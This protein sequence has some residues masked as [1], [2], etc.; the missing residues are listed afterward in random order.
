MLLY[1]QTPVGEKIK[2][3]K[4]YFDNKLLESFFR[5]YKIKF[6]DSGTSALAAAILACINKKNI[7]MPEVIIPAYSCPDLVSAILFA[8]GSPV[9]V[10]FIKDRP[11]ID[12]DQLQEKITSNTV[13]IIAVN[14]FGIPERLQ[15]IKDIA[16][17]EDITFIEDSAQSFP[18]SE[19]SIKWSGD[20]V[21][22]SFGRGKPVN[23]LTGGAVLFLENGVDE[24]LPE[25]HDDLNS[26]FVETIKYII[27]SNIYNLT[28]SPYV[29]GFLEKM[30]FLHVGET[31][32][33]KHHC[34]E[35]M[36]SA[37]LSFLHRN[38]KLFS[39]R[40]NEIQSRY[41]ELLSSIH[42]GRL[43]DLPTEC[44][45]GNKPHILRYPI[46]CSDVVYREKIFLNLRTKGIGVSKMYQCVIPK[47]KG[48]NS[49]VNIGG[50]FK[51]AVAFAD[52]LITLPMHSRTTNVGLKHIRA[53]LSVD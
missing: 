16:S 4:P 11:W 53:I 12:L 39:E 37:A 3:G 41:T 13:A 47:V 35:P 27:K 40:T 36:N 52:R 10:D 31:R 50:T 9:L 22:L 51:N 38:I 14:L 32:F 33:K 23:M 29:Y 30:P 45:G 19:N 25:V 17:K 21:I 5:P 44:C 7:K 6:Y 26:S 46:L 2:L 24:L 15:E 28:I 42:N 1:Q 48:M 43:I 20:I 49:Q 34:I 18:I 8:G